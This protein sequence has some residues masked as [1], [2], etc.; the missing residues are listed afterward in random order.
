LQPV[1]FLLALGLG[2]GSQVRAGSATA[3]VSY[4]HYIAP[5]LLVSAAMQNGVGESTY[6]VLSGFKWQKDYLAVT[7][8]PVT[9]GQLLAGHFTWT[10]LRLLLS[11]TVYALIATAFGAWL[12]AGAIG[13]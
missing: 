6:P 7:A 9:P 12:N 4:L 10:C 1:L 8:T 11:S 5:A 13:V 3:G 2:F